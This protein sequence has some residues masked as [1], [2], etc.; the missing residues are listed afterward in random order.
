MQQTQKTETQ[1]PF[2]LTLYLL[3]V[4]GLSWPFQL[5]FAL[6]D[7]TLNLG[8]LNL[9]SM[10]MVTVGTFI[11]GRYVFRDG[12]KHAGWRW[13]KPS[14]YLW[15]FGLALF[16]FAVPSLFE[17]L[18]GLHA[19]PSGIS[20]GTILA[21]FAA[22]FLLTLIPGFGEEFGW[23]GY[24]L[25][26]LVKQYSTRKA[27]LVHAFIWWAWHLPVI[28]TIGIREGV[29]AG[30]GESILLITLITL[31]PSM[32]NAV[33]FAYVWTATK[34]LAV[35][36][37]YHSAYDEVRDGIEKTVGFGPLISIWEM[38]VTTL[39]GVFL[40]WKGNWKPLADEKNK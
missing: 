25:R 14:Q 1:R 31:I 20:A 21:S 8:Y 22:S 37:V 2:S 35:A 33:I 12:F 15:T 24:M 39:L 5:V 11:A 34:S 4:F 9:I 36:S 13:G 16:I 32:M 26:H 38:L 19:L 18:L 3:I 6:S 28:F 27:I 10:V 40:L 17:N 30:T 29:G 7:E 23:R